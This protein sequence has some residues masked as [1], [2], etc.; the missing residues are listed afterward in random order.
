[1][2]PYHTYFFPIF[3]AGL[4]AALIVSLLA[5]WRRGCLVPL[6]CLPLGVL[7]FWSG[8]FF[9]AEIGYRQW[10]GMPNPPDEAFADTAPLGALLLG[11]LPASIFCG[12][13]F[14]FTRLIRQFVAPR[15][16]KQTSPAPI[17]PNVDHVDRVETG[18][19][20]QAP[21]GPEDES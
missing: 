2:T 19:P 3:G 8:L 14:G 1:M 10:Q 11:W 18:N 4:L 16:I 17:S 21:L 13:V 7:S 12:F 6:V 20:Y 15:D 5:G 9:G